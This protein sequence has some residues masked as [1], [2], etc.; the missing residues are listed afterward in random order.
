MCPSAAMG[1]DGGGNRSKC[2]KS[3][4]GSELSSTERETDF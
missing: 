3:S 4:V 2:S 1:A